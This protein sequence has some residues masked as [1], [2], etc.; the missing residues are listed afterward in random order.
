MVLNCSA[1]HY[2]AKL[3]ALHYGAKLR[4]TTCMVVVHCS[5]LYYDNELFCTAL[6]YSSLLYRTALWYCNAVHTV[7]TTALKGIAAAM[8]QR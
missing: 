2:G 1:L 7:T 4:C 8:N 5:A 3:T 6:L